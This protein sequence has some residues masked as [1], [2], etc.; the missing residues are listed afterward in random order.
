[1]INFVLISPHFPSN[2]WLFAGFENRG[3]RVLGI[4]DTP[5]S[6]CRKRCAQKLDDVVCV[7]SMTDRDAMIRALGY[8][9]WKYGKI[10]W[11]E[12]NNE[13]WLNLDA[14]YERAVPRHDGMFP[15]GSTSVSSCR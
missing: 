11:I 13:Y 10:D 9:T 2:Y 14:E 6:R 1:M 12:S 15:G 7:Y 3:V 4:I 8:F 5:W